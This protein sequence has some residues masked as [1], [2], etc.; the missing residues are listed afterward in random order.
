MNARQQTQHSH[1]AAASQEAMQ[2]AAKHESRCE[3][4]TALV[5]E[6]KGMVEGRDA[7]RVCKCWG[8]GAYRRAAGWGQARVVAHGAAAVVHARLLAPQALCV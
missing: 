6:A 3:R 7:M 4:L 2:A 8:G 1:T 5:A